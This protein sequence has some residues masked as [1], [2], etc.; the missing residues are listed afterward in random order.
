MAENEYDTWKKVA[1]KSKQ[2]SFDFVGDVG[3]LLQTLFLC[4]IHS[5]SFKCVCNFSEQFVNMA[6]DLSSS[7][8]VQPYIRLLNKRMDSANAFI[9]FINSDMREYPFKHEGD[10]GGTKHCLADALFRGRCS[11]SWN[12]DECAEA[13]EKRKYIF[14][15]LLSSIQFFARAYTLIK[16]EF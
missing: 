12:T 5:Q 2:L 9:E 11:K 13:I 10:T 15:C 4:L 7:V 1:I 3:F 14:F 6:T 8:Y 16:V